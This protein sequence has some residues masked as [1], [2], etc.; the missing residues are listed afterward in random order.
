MVEGG[1]EA[2]PLIEEQNKPKAFQLHRLTTEEMT[3]FMLSNTA[4]ENNGIFIVSN[5]AGGYSFHDRSIQPGAEYCVR[6][7]AFY[8][9]IFEGKIKPIKNNPVDDWSSVSISVGAAAG[10]FWMAMDPFI[11][12]ESVKIVLSAAAVPLL[13][14]CFQ[15]MKAKYHGKYDAAEIHKRAR[16]LTLEVMFSVTGWMA[17]A[18][19]GSALELGPGL[20][21]ITIA[22]TDAFAVGLASLLNASAD[23]GNLEQIKGILLNC[24]NLMW[25]AAVSA[26]IWQVI[27]SNIYGVADTLVDSIGQPGASVV[28][29]AL[30]GTLVAG[31]CYGLYK[32]TPKLFEGI[33]SCCKR[34]E[35]DNE[36]S[37]MEGQAKL[38]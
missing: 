29:A 32:G 18:N 4:G 27:S 33:I 12:E 35:D 19:L 20:T 37:E 2:Q 14:E 17:G 24:S 13:F 36:G 22:L 16:N 26:S 10:F 9:L 8:Q 5:P 28:K 1:N 30:N 31:V 25:T 7:D 23:Y 38:A 15:T 3:G 6:R 11:K 21:T 34:K